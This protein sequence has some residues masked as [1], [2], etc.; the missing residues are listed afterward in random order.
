MTTKTDFTEEEWTRVV[1]APLVA[2]MAVSLADPGGPIEATKES[3]ASLKSATNPPSREQLL[4]EVALEVQAMA[5]ERHNPLS[6]FKL[7]KDRPP[8]EQVLDELRGVHRI[9]ADKATPEEQEA[10]GEWLVVAA[11]AAADAAKEGGFMGIGAERVSAGEREMLTSIR[12]AVAGD[13]PATG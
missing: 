11:Q 10:F 2:G 9:V 13:A 5:Q 3:V 12:A 4:A 6:G 8:G 1:R 7:A